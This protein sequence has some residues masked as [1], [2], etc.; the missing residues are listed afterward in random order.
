MARTAVPD[1]PGSIIN[2][3]TVVPADLVHVGSAL[4]QNLDGVDSALFD[5]L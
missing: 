5:G 4:E 2:L 1:H 3:P